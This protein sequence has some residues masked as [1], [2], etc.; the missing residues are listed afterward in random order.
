VNSKNVPFFSYSFLFGS[1][2]AEFLEVVTDVGRRGAFIL[3]KDLVN[4]E[5][6]L[7]EFVGARRALGVGNG[8][9]WRSRATVAFWSWE[10]TLSRRRFP[11]FGRHNCLWLLPAISI[12]VRTVRH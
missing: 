12:S 3:Q 8:A 7:A 1:S 11:R 5:Q 2:E 4:F 9:N 10:R 6:H